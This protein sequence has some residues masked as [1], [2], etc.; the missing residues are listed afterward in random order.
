MS[1]F[2]LWPLCPLLRLNLTIHFAFSYD[3]WPLL[4]LWCCMVCCQQELSFASLVFPPPHCRLV[5]DLTVGPWHINTIVPSPEG[6]QLWAHSCPISSLHTM[7]CVCCFFLSLPILT[8][9]DEFWLINNT[10]W[11]VCPC[12]IPLFSLIVSL[13]GSNL[14]IAFPL[15]SH[16]MPASCLPHIPLVM[17]L[18]SDDFDPFPGSCALTECCTVGNWLF[19]N[20]HLIHFSPIVCAWIL[21]HMPLGLFVS[22]NP[23]LWTHNMDQPSVLQ[24]YWHFCFSTSNTVSWR[25]ESGLAM[26]KDIDLVELVVWA[27]GAS[28][29]YS[30]FIRKP[31]SAL[32][33]S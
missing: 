19:V 5:Y 27:D 15:L 30:V 8:T 11:P 10:V 21:R 25:L 12:L 14:S 13:Q 28:N 22:L 24:W 31:L 20:C 9:F 4:S 3:P 16:H 1:H 7:C 17:L 33:L 29:S 2:C 18:P 23:F 6:R 32:T 26:V